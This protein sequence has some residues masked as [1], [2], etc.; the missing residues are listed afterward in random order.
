MHWFTKHLR[1]GGIASISILFLLLCLALLPLSAASAHEITSRSA[2]PVAVQTTPTEDATVTA[3]NKEQLAQQVAGQ[4]HTWENWLWGNAATISSTLVIV[5]GALVGLWRWYRERRDA[6]DKELKERRDAQDKELQERQNELE[7][8]A[9]ERFQAAVIGLGDDKEGVRAGAAILLRTFLHPGYEQF[10][11]QT[12]DLAVAHLR[13]RHRNPDTAEPLDTLSQALITVF[14]EA[15]PLA[16]DQ[17]KKE[18]IPFCPQ[19]L[20]G[21]YIQLDSAY[22][23]G[24]DLKHVW[25]P[26]ASLRHAD[27]RE[28]DLTQANLRGADL[29]NAN[30]GTAN[31]TGANL[32]GA[33]LTEAFLW[34]AKLSGATL[35]GAKLYNAEL[36]VADLSGSELSPARLIGA[37]LGG[38]NLQGAGLRIG[39]LSGANFDGANLSGAKLTG[40]KLYE[41][42]LEEALSLKETDLRRVKGL[43]KEQLEACKARGAIVDEDPAPRVSQPTGASGEPPPRSNETPAPPAG[44]DPP[45]PDPDE[46]NTQPPPEAE[47]ENC[48]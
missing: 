46:S 44:E 13:L 34:E 27:L 6:Q 1:N 40:S 28:A 39:D 36:G 19:S 20:V 26:Q 32:S 16:R 5:L 43:T 12:F 8:R 15:F 47:S 22:L 14:K 48:S 21:R 11:T 3:L 7:K 23:S 38:A 37:N 4:Q 42:N 41:V 10:Y 18:T 45:L 9:E 33:N 29:T 24:A 25:I 35:N 31:L 2:T 30:L 17:L